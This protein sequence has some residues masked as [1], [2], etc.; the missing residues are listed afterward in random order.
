VCLDTRLTTQRKHQICSGVKNDCKRVFK[1]LKSRWTKQLSG[2][3]S[4]AKCEKLAYSLHFMLR[5]RGGRSDT[6]GKKSG[7]VPSFLKDWC[8]Y[9]PLRHENAGTLTIMC[10]ELRDELEDEHFSWIHTLLK[11]ESKAIL[12]LKELTSKLCVDIQAVCK[13][14]DIHKLYKPLTKSKNDEL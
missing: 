2:K 12:S 9:L 13:T 14:K 5:T 3:K 11:R 7:I 6:T 10:E 1:S 8:D 4:C